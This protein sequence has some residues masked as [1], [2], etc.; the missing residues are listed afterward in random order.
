[1]VINWQKLVVF[2]GRATHIQ[3]MYDEYEDIRKAVLDAA[4]PEIAFDG[5]S[6]DVL[7]R[8]GEA[9]GVD[10][11]SLHL[12]F[13]GGVGDLIAAFSSKGDAAMLATLDKPDDMKIR[14][15][16]RHAVRVRLE[17]DTDHREAARRA[18][19]WLSLPGR[20]ALGGRLIYATADHIWHWAGDKTTDYNHYSKR[21]ILSGV[22]GAT[23]L[24][25]LGDESDGN[26][27]SWAFLDRRIENVMQF[28]KTK[29]KWQAVSDGK[30]PVSDFL[31]KLARQRYKTH[32]A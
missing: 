7:V 3:R 15:R 14:D 25:W 24:V 28:E 20:Q 29:S 11:N 22:M 19:G 10:D 9:A 31:G 17:A 13:S 21:L 32:S 16:I 4:L 12:A 30:T 1:M 2:T 8:A 26:E 6:E 23:R 5:W 27:K 18:A